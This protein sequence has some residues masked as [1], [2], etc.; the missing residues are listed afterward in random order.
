MILLL[1]QF[2]IHPQTTLKSFKFNA[3][4][5]LTLLNIVPSMIIIS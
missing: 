5:I 3:L 2:T 1:Q 4:Q